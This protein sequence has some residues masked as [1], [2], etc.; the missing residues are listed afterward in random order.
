[1]RQY[2]REERAREIKAEIRGLEKGHRFLNDLERESE[3]DIE[4]NAGG[5]KLKC[6]K[7]IE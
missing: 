3:K 7:E 2:E 4:E 5:E 1:V 6:L